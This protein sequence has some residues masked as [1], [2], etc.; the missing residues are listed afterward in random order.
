MENK[1]EHQDF[2]QAIID[3][4]IRSSTGEAARN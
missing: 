2:G 1:N 3:A 4:A